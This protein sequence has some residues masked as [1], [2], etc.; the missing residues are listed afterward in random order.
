MSSRVILRQSIYVSDH[1]SSKSE[2]EQKDIKMKQT[3][4]M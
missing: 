3:K 4:Y 2:Y 1:F